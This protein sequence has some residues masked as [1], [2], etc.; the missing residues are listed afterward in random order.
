MKAFRSTNDYSTPRQTRLLSYIAEFTGNVEFINGFLNIAR[1]ALSRA[2]INA[3]SLIS[4]V[5]PLTEIATR[6]HDA[7]FEASLSSSKYQSL[8]LEKRFLPASQTSI[9]GDTSKGTFRVVVP[10]SLTK[11]VFDAM[12][13]FSHPGIKGTQRMIGDR[14]LWHGMKRDITEWCRTCIKGRKCKIF[15][16]NRAPLGDF[17]EACACFSDVHSDLV[18][19]L[20]LSNGCSYLLTCI[21]RYTRWLE[22]IPLPDISAA[23]CA[24]AFLLHWIARFRCPLNLSTDRGGQFCSEL[25]NNFCIN[26]GINLKNTTAY[27][28]ASNGIIENTHRTIKTALKAHENPHNWHLNLGLVFR[29]GV[30]EDVLGLED[31]FEDTFSS[32]WPWSW[33]RTLKS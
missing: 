33:P 1:N 13:S 19:P 5:L 7:E 21:D 30:L 20:P 26:F 24:N 28:P 25:F 8:L 18:G 2:E 15:R 3:V 27:H 16:H 9:I 29:G 22:V 14:F 17:I 12:H 31:V 11:R 4:E 6:Q 10:T 32:P 23:T